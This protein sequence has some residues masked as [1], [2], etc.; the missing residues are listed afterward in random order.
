[1][2][3]QL[4]VHGITSPIAKPLPVLIVGAGP[5]GLTMATALHQ[6]GISYRIIE[7]LTKPLET[8]NAAVLHSRTLEMLDDLDIV[9]PFLKEGQHIDFLRLYRGRKVL[10]KM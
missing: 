10:A 2:T 3:D 7:K 4:P 1:M 8:S 6:Y 9:D 5:S